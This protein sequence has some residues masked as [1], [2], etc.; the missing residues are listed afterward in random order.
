MN[1]IKTYEGGRN[2]YGTEK[3]KE[4]VLKRFS[5]FD[6]T[7]V[8]LTR[9]DSYEEA[10]TTA[11]LNYTG[12]KQ[13]MYLEDG[14]IVSNNFCVVKSDDPTIQL[15]VVGK[16]YAPVGNN[17]AFE[18]AEELF[19]R[20]D[21]RFEAGGPAL[22]S[23][24]ATDYSRSFLVMRGDDIRLGSDDMSEVFN[25]FLVFRNSFS[26]Q[27]GIQYRV[28]LQRLVC[29]NGMTRYLGDKKSQ[30]FINIQHSKSAIDK[31]KIANEALR[32]RENEIKAI[33]AE[34]EA[35]SLT[36][37]TK[38]EFDREIIPMVLKTLKLKPLETPREE[39]SVAD[40]ERRDLTIQRLW[41]AYQADDVAAYNNTA[42]KVILAMSDID[43]HMSPFRDTQNPSLYMNRVLQGMVLTTGV[44]KYIAQTRGVVPKY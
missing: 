38:A 24:R 41:N 20:G 22:G 18:I 31:I 3:G 25:S 2:I 16:D 34:V 23:K 4:K 28:I 12:Q 13:K 35:F 27:T 21:M 6:G 17:E 36:H 29:L 42:Y 39:L 11:G 40:E 30:L 37:F 26:G 14:S 44:A 5:M 15:G 19:N 43:T 7:G 10:M 8:D 9:C 32:N 1:E 33:Q